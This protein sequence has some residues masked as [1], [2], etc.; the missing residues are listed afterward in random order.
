MICFPSPLEGQGE[1]KW[2]QPGL[3]VQALQEKVEA[4]YT[5]NS[6]FWANAHFTASIESLRVEKHMRKMAFLLE[7]RFGIKLFEFLA[8]QTEIS[9]ERLQFSDQIFKNICPCLSFCVH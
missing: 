1:Q 6:L 9:F 7:A 4:V 2:H 5:Q 3:E 8:F